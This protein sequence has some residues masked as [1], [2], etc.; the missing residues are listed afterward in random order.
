[1][2]AIIIFTAIVCLFAIVGCDCGA[3]S[4][5]KSADGI[6]YKIVTVEGRKFIATPTDRNFWVLAGPID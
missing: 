6:R 3:A 4:T 2:K 5:K 1:M